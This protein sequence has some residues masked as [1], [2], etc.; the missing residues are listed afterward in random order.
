MPAVPVPPT[1]N[2]STRMLLSLGLQEAVLRSVRAHPPPPGSHGPNHFLIVARVCSPM[3]S[4][5]FL[6]PAVE[7]RRPVPQEMVELECLAAT[8]SPTTS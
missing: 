4:H 8:P 2:Q 6:A 7:C 5:A 1:V 3:R